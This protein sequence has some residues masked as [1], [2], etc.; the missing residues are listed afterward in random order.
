MMGKPQPE[1]AVD[2]LVGPATIVAACSSLAPLW[3]IFGNPPEGFT[4]FTKVLW[5]ASLL[6][7]GYVMFKLNKALLL[8]LVLLTSIV[9]VHLFAVFGGA[10]FVQWHYAAAGAFA[11]CAVL[12]P[13][14]ADRLVDQRE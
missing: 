9:G 12:M 5:V 7:V 11:V 8:L 2:E 6:L 1:T 14:M 4:V 3:T 10:A 13:L